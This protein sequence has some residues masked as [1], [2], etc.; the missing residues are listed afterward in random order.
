MASIREIIRYLNSCGLTPC[1]GCVS[2]TGLRAIHKCIFQA[3]NNTV[4]KEILIDELSDFYAEK[5]NI[6]NIWKSL[7]SIEREITACIVR[8]DGDDFIPAIGEYAKKYHISTEYKPKWGVKRDLLDGE[9]YYYVHGRFIHLLNNYKPDT[10]T[11]LF[12]PNGKDMPDFVLDVLKTVLD[13]LKFEYKDYVPAEPDHIIRRESRI[14]DFAALVRFTASERLKVKKNTYDLTKAKL[15]KLA[16]AIGL[17]EVYDNGGKFGTPKEVSGNND[18]KV[19]QPLFVLAANSRLV[20][21]DSDGNVT[22]GL[23]SPDL[24]SLPFKDQAKK[25]FEDYFNENSISELDY[26]TYIT[27][28]GSDYW[29]N[30]HECRKSIIDLLKTCPSEKFISFDD[31]NRYMK[32]ARGNFFRRLLNGSVT[33]KGYNFGR[34]YGR[35]RPDWDECEAQIIRLVLSFLSAI[36]MVDAVYSE[37]VPRIKFNNDDYCVGISGFCITKLGAWILGMSKVYKEPENAVARK[38]EGGLFILPDY[39]VMITGLKYRVEHETYLSQFLTKISTDGNAAVYKLDFQSAVR[40][41]NIGVTPQAL[42]EYLTKI[43]SV[44]L[45]DN[46]GRSLDDWQAKIGR[47]RISNLTVL[48][49]DDPLL[50]EE[51]KHIKGMELIVSHGLSNAAAINGDQIKKAKALIEKNGWL[52]ML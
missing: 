2:R 15:A 16:E 48:E 29:V 38:D 5:Q 24:L 4:P 47:V 35:Y 45:P 41:F 46:V 10:K 31:F 22:P 9:D 33:V 21:I 20:E 13:P 7:S 44:P 37:N 34:Y 49:T 6:I 40:A 19:A 27:S 42:K 30:W 11:V 50:L 26:I 25:L 36:G 1:D 8:L 23:I 52:V 51:L 32:S 12:F 28:Y 39:S 18:F 43:S 3:K 14:S 17:E